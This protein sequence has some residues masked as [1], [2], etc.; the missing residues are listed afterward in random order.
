MSDQEFVSEKPEQNAIVSQESEAEGASLAIEQC[1]HIKI[2]G[3][4]CGS[5][6]LRGHQLCYF[7]QN[8]RADAKSNRQAQIADGTV[9]NSLDAA[10]DA[11]PDSLPLLEDA[12]AIQCA[13]F[14]T[15]RELRA[16]RLDHRT[17]A[18]MLYGLQT[19]SANLRH[20]SLNP[21]WEDVTVQQQPLLSAEE[22]EDAQGLT[23]DDD[24]EAADDPRY[25]GLTRRDLERF[26][27]SPAASLGLLGGK[28]R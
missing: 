24:G 25:P 5:P 21:T 8:W 22:Y 27:P 12:D 13:I 10:P 9:R 4:R 11:L 28:R 19:A 6:A 23:D 2:N 15:L 14:N 17:A 3:V 18:L 7:H 20:V 26:G 1:H 16:G